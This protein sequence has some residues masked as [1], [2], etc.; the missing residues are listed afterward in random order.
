MPT[1]N[2][3][4]DR[5]GEYTFHQ[6]KNY[7]HSHGIHHQKSCLHMPE[8]NGVVEQKHQYIVESGMSMMRE[9]CVHFGL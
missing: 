3:H 6:Y 1:V 8:Q 4:N 2:F 9:S 7:L 5:G